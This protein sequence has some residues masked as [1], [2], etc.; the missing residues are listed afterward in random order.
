MNMLA[1]KHSLGELFGLRVSGNRYLLY[2]LFVDDVG[3]FLKNTLQEFEC[4][5]ATIQNFE[6]ISRAFLNVAKSMIVPLVNPN[7]QEWFASIGCKVLLSSKTT[8]Y[9]G[10]LIGHKVSPQQETDFLLDKV[11][12]RLSHWANQSLSF[13]GRTILLRHV[14]CAMPIYHFMTMTL[15]WDGFDKLECISRNF[16]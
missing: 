4:A 15:N 13:A 12:K 3:L 9:L 14:I 6:D 7:P 11:R 16:L 2:Q 8:I 5:R 10:C 1:M